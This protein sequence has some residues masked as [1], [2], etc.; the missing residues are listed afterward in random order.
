MIKLKERIHQCDQCFRIDAI[1]LECDH[2]SCLNCIKDFAKEKSTE[3]NIKTFKCPSCNIDIPKEVTQIYLIATNDFQ[4]FLN[5][6]KNCE[7]CLTEQEIKVF[8]KTKKLIC[9]HCLQNEGKAK[10]KIDY[11]RP[12]IEADIPVN[13]LDRKR[14]KSPDLLLEKKPKIDQKQEE[15]KKGLF[16]DNDKKVS[17][18]KPQKPVK[19][20]PNTS[21]CIQCKKAPGQASPCGHSFCQACLNAL[22]RSSLPLD[23]FSPTKCSQCSKEL[24][25]SFIESSFDSALQFQKFQEQ[26][27]NNLYF[28]ATFDCGVCMGKFRIEEGITFECDHRFCNNCVKEYFREK[29]MSSNVSEDELTCPS[30]G[31]AIDHNIIQGLDKELYDKYLNFAFR[32]WKPEEGAVLKYCCFCDAAAEIPENL[33]RFQCPK[34]K[35]SYC[36]QC[37]Q[38]HQARVTC[39]E[40]ARAELEKK[41]PGRAGLE[42]KEKVQAEAGDKRKG[43]EDRKGEEVGKFGVEERKVERKETGKNLKAAEREDAGKGKNPARVEDKVEVKGKVREK[44]NS[45]VKVPSSQANDGYLE[46]LKKESRRCP[47]CK[48]FVLKDSGCNFIKCRWPGC[49]DSYFCYLCSAVLKSTQHYSHYKT[50]GPFGRTCNKLDNIKDEA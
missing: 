11:K 25:Q 45:Q 14:V 39:E 38:N 31:V 50:S 37:N 23:P 26:C 4:V 35:K 43:V 5:S 12:R 19:Q 1:R 49:K 44:S 47:K 2:R 16:Q 21:L 17:P 41:E 10:R 32:N 48:N 33:K 34:C 40:F 36:P 8:D 9:L 29:I 7:F 20:I 18:N 27:V 6:L 42:R 46:Q 30:C 24:P 13:G 15:V 22:A 28:S 3:S